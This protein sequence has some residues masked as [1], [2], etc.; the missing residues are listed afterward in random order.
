VAWTDN[1]QEDNDNV[2]VIA[3]R[4][5]GQ[6]RPVTCKPHLPSIGG[7]K[8]TILYTR[9]Q[10]AERLRRA[11][12]EREQ[13]GR[14][15]DIFLA[16]S[17]L[18]SKEEDD[19]PT[20]TT[21]SPSP[22]TDDISLSAP[23]NMIRDSSCAKKNTLPSA[24]NNLNN[25]LYYSTAAGVSKI[26]PL[27]KN[28]K[29]SFL[30]TNL[31]AQHSGRRVAKGVSDALLD[32]AADEPEEHRAIGDIPQIELHSPI[33]A[34]R[35]TTEIT[36][37]AFPNSDITV[38]SKNF[39]A[40]NKVQNHKNAEANK[41]ETSPS[42]K[43]TV[44]LVKTMEKSSDKVNVKTVPRDVP[45]AITFHSSSLLCATAEDCHHGTE[46]N[47]RTAVDVSPRKKESL[48]ADSIRPGEV[49]ANSCTENEQESE[50]RTNR[51]EAKQN[52]VNVDIMRSFV[53]FSDKES[54]KLVQ[55]SQTRVT[56]TTD[57]MSATA[58]RVNFRNSINNT[59][60]GSFSSDV[61]PSSKMCS[62]APA[63]VT[64]STATRAL[65]APGRSILVQKNKRPPL[66][67]GISVDM[68]DG[69]EADKG[70]VAQSVAPGRRRSRTAE[71]RRKVGSRQRPGEDIVTMVSLLSD[72]SDQEADPTGSF[73][74]HASWLEGRNSPAGQNQSEVVIVKKPPKSGKC[75]L[76]V[77]LVDNFTRR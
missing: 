63:A 69:E 62:P 44:M 49:S 31:S 45:P 19:S 4:C 32:R 68:S 25:P 58:R 38:S 56:S 18:V 27:K 70:T 61:P 41:T 1:R 23:R 26:M 24:Q 43:S 57:V 30:R 37:S 60:T 64:R 54:C 36:S 75:L 47:K 34:E 72:G 15:L 73:L 11:W 74:Q 71:P 22:I 28:S 21:Q 14:S 51:E 52:K 20:D 6:P 40:D 48:L 2:E 7:D 46:T 53:T 50:F 55:P 77:R 65:S 76:T 10:L 67:R 59:I 3:K 42:N 8:D 12:L 39:T 9:Q 29:T 17:N 35:T 66:Q 33:S 13:S 5:T 16:H